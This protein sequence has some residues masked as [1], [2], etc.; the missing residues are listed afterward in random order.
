MATGKGTVIYH[1]PY[2]SD[3]IIPLL[4]QGSI[5]I[6]PHQEEKKTASNILKFRMS[7]AISTFC[8]MFTSNR[9]TFMGSVANFRAT[10]CSLF[11]PT[12]RFCIDFSR[13]VLCDICLS[14]KW[15]YYRARCKM[16]FEHVQSK[17]V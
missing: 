14:Q 16:F 5:I 9:V 8:H 4:K 13:R 17:S 6:F 12:K 15:F 10:Q 1:P 2:G 11:S 3:E 7:E